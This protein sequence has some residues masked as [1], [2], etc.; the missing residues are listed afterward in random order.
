MGLFF[1]LGLF[2]WYAR[3]PPGWSQLFLGSACKENFTQ[4]IAKKRQRGQESQKKP[5]Y[6]GPLD[7][8][9]QERLADVV[10]PLW[11]LSY[12]EQLKVKFEAHKKILQRLEFYLQGLNGVNMTTT[13]P[14]SQGLGC[15]LQPIIP[16]VSP[17]CPIL[18]LL[19]LLN[20]PGGNPKTVGHYLG[21]W[22]VCV[23]SN[24]LKNIPEKHSQVAQ[25]IKNKERLSPLGPCLLFHEG[26]YWR[27][28]T[29]CT[30]SQG[31]T[32]AIIIFLSPGINLSVQKEA[33]KEFF[34][35]GAGAV[36]D[37][38]SLY[39]QESTTTHCSHQQGVNS[40]TILL[41]VCCGTGGSPG[42]NL[43]A[44]LGIELVEQAAE[45][46]R[47]TAPW[48][49]HVGLS[50]AD[51]TNC[52]FHPGQAETILPQLLKSKED[53]QLIVAVVNPAWAGLYYQVVQANCNCGAIHTLVFASCKPHGEITR[54]IIELCCPPN[55]TKKFLGKPF[56]PRQAV[57]MDL[58]SRS[59]HCELVLLF[60][61]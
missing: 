58:F 51:I 12:E 54:N 47:W 42:Q 34:T 5:R 43:H 31:H 28:L 56:I 41:D 45:D 19:S 21:T 57:P 50:F 17:Y 3:K 18:Y 48:L 22:R 16:S 20:S 33:V 52:E 55:S 39:F 10:M 26:G 44:V 8:S 9:W 35:K 53:G 59:P 27:E 36:C 14:R 15:F 49:W 25:V 2:P 32:M 4:V 38:T 30:N 60:T 40:N 61:R 1:K 13:G 37:L 6:L 23:R 11:R 46:A 7:D 29:V 24:R